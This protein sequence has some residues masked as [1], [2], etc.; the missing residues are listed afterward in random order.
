V[1]FTKRLRDPIKRGEITTSIRI[2]KSPR[3]KVG[4]RYKL[5]EGFIVIEKISA[6]ELGDITPEL[7]RESGFAGVVDLLKIA[8][9]GA[10]ENVYLI[11][12]RYEGIERL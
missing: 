1:Q 5:E 4:H 3:V 7:A 11:R 12:F 10:G 6:I 9:H 2:W 8:K